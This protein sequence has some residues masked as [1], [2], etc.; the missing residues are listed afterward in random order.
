MDPKI[1]DLAPKDSSIKKQFWDKFHKTLQGQMLPEQMPL[2]HL[3]WN[4]K[5]EGVTVLWLGWVCMLGPG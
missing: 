3:S 4:V 5:C 1:K 2:V